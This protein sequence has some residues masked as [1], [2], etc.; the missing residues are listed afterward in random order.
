MKKISILICFII[1]FTS[2]LF[3]QQKGSGNPTVSNKMTELQLQEIIENVEM[4]K[5]T[6]E[7]FIPLY[8]EYMQKVRPK[9]YN[10]FGYK[11][12][13]TLNYD[14][15]LDKM[16][17]GRFEYTKE[18]ANMRYEYHLKFREFLSPRQLHKIYEIEKRTVDKLR[19][20]MHDRHK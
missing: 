8:R 9:R 19:K 5:A 6:K 15:R 17:M 7:K 10:F 1:A 13:T 4:D 18:V 11:R 14:E 3:A 2:V 16:M 12:D 20:M